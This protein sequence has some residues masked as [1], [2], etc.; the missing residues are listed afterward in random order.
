MMI[1]TPGR[2]LEP[3]SSGALE[4][5]T[6]SPRGLLSDEEFEIHK[7]INSGGSGR[8]GSFWAG[9]SRCGRRALLS[10][11]KYAHFRDIESTLPLLKNHFLVGSIYH[12]LHENWRMEFPKLSA[13][14]ATPDKYSNVNVQEGARLFQGYASNWSREMWGETLAVERQLPE[15]ADVASDIMCTFGAEL[16]GKVDMVVELRH[17]HLDEA[18]RRLPEIAPGFYIVDFKTAEMPGNGLG[19]QMG[20]QSLVY[21]YL[22]NQQFPSRP[23]SGTIFD[24]IYKRSRRKPAPFTSGDFGA[25]FAPYKIENQ[26]HVAASLK[27]MIQQG[28]YTTE[29]FIPNR[30]E[31]C[32]WRGEICQYFN[33]EC[34]AEV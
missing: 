32:S 10:E 5:L 19:Y 18:R 13:M 21:P 30:S 1:E 27:G 29:N 23:V 26:A 28:K 22:W 14:D 9:A 4:P 2:I 11:R 3:G 12:L 7:G 20:L 31:C 25:Y 34:D 33:K 15:S 6:T 17:E 24:V 16:T 8:G